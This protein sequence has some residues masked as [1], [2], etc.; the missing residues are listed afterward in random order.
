LHCYPQEGNVSQTND[1][2]ATELL[3]NSS[4][5]QFWD[6]NYV[7]PSWINS[8]IMLIPRMQNWVATYY[9][10]TKI[11]ITE[12]NWG[13]E[14]YINGATAQADILGIFGR[15]SL[16]LATRWTTP[17]PSTPT[18][19]AIKMYR[20]YDGNKSTFGDT[21]ISAI[22]PD[23]DD[24]AGFAAQR[25]NDGSLT[26]MAVSKYLT[27]VTPLSI[28]VSNFLG[29]GT[30][31]MWQLNSSNAITR[32]SDVSYAGGT[33][34]ATVPGQ[35]ITLFVLPAKPFTLQP[36]AAR[37]GGQINFFLNGEIGQTYVLQSSSNL[38]NWLPI[39]TNTLTSTQWSFLV[40]AS[41]TQGFYRARQGP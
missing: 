16:D 2:S 36:G 18:Y 1:D 33:I 17:D 7:D 5:R 9:P 20:N 14:P 15:Q 3:R 37:A 6:T 28:S 35:S 4:T 8:I 34:N 12:Y 22:G 32:L 41:S 40:T 38:I 25:T 29:T 11:G 26:I 19:L 23:P 31:Q 13:A 30:A 10:G 24:V 27:G 21:S 39:S